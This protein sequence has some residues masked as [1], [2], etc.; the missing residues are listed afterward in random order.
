MNK[1]EKRLH[2]RNEVVVARFFYWSDIK[3]RRFDDAINKLENE[4]FF[5]EY[6]TIS[7]ILSVYD[8]YYTSLKV[9]PRGDIVIKYLKDTYPSWNWN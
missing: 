8:R 9:M 2:K 6:Q 5:I 7:K 1:R 4:E 3:R